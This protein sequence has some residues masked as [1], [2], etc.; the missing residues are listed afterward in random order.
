MAEK[1][2]QQTIKGISIIKIL[3][4]IM[5]VMFYRDFHCSEIKNKMEFPNYSNQINTTLTQGKTP[6]KA[7]RSYNP[8]RQNLSTLD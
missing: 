1:P 2:S 6:N 5:P 7:N 8:P 3:T 4:L